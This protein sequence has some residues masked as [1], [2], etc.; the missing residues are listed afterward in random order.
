MSCFLKKWGVLRW[1]NK[2]NGRR[3]NFNFIE[4]EEKTWVFSCLI[5]GD[6]KIGSENTVKLNICFKKKS[7][8]FHLF[9]F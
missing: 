2:I 4:E 3:T 7:F 1:I 9:F 8:F 6:K 5:G